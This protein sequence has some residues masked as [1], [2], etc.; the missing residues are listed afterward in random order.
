MHAVV[1]AGIDDAAH[2]SG[3]NTY[4]RR[5]LRGLRDLGWRV[6]ER[7]A[8]GS[9]PR[10]TPS[11]LTGLRRILAAVPA[12]GV[13]LVD[14][15]VASAAG[16]VLRPEANRL[17]L[18]V[19]MHMPLQTDDE[20]DVLRRAAG[21]ITT[22]T[23]TRDRLVD[24]VVD[25]ARLTVAEPGTDPAAVAVPSPG[26][27]RLLSVGVVGVHKGQDVLIDAL[28]LL[29]DLTW[30]C[31]VVGALDVDPIFAERTRRAAAG[32][33][34]R[35]R[36]RGPLVGTDL[37]AAYAQADLLVLPSRV[38]TFGMVIGEALSRGIPVV[39]AD[40]GGV[41]LA[42]GHDPSGGRPG[43]LV[44][45]GDAIALAR[46]LRRWLDDGGL[47]DRLRA[48]ARHRRFS[49]AGWSTTTRRVSDALREVGI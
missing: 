31:T 12:G 18:V 1:P 39:A 36:F 44:R 7:R 46:A 29:G 8:A 42:L 21:V 41:R 49:L 10:P 35:V 6:E 20:R 11:D 14:G 34:D 48:S 4:D 30:S 38:E 19:L 3:G 13:V 15:L 43:L 22:S 23:W 2:P 17:R 26:G 32:S 33:A 16:G 45:P 47:R 24:H 25:R 27:G 9:W 40:V 28:A 5:V 37:A